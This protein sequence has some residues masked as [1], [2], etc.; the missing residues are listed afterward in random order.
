MLHNP[1][2]S[3]DRVR[4][5]TNVAMI[6]GAACYLVSCSD[7]PTS[8]LNQQVS[9]TSSA[10]STARM[11]LMSQ[12][13]YAYAIGDLF[14]PDVEVTQTIP[15]APR[16]TGLLAVGTGV[17]A[18]T[19]SMVE[20]FHRDS[21]LIAEQVVGKARREFLVPCKPAGISAA[22]A[23]C[24]DKFITTVGRRLFRRPL[25]EAEHKSMVQAAG[26]GAVRLKDFYAGLSFT[27]A[28]MI[29]SPQ[30]MLLTETTEVDPHNARRQRLT[31]YAKAQR[32]SLF[33]WDSIPDE[34]L[35]RAAE[36]GDL[37]TE[38]GV[39][40]QIDRLV[41]SPQLERGVRAFFSDMLA[42]ET[43]AD[44]AKDNVIYPAFTQAT[45]PEAKEQ[46]LRMIA[47]HLVA[48]RG[49]YRELFTSRKT[50]VTP[51]LA[52]L[53]GI[54][55]PG[56]GWSEY[57]IPQSSQR[58]GLLSQVGFTS[59]YAHPGRSSPTRR[60]KAIREL[61][62]CQ[63]VPDPPANV[64]FSGFEDPRG[65]M[66]TARDR[67]TAHATNPVCAGCHKITDP[68]GL[69]LENFDG[70]GQFRTTEG[71]AAIDPSGTLDGVAF[72][73]PE[74]LGKALHDSPALTSCLVS[75]LYSFAL[76]KAPGANE[77]DYLETLRAKFAG[78]GYRV[79]DL[80]R[81]ISNDAAFFA[82]AAAPTTVAG[83][84]P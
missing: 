21:H 83:V 51:N 82:L 42:F 53:M 68:I 50:F 12:D 57:E 35:L 64:D 4:R 66:N 52:I 78:A 72:N 7:A 1:Y 10:A 15:R 73:T 33:F 67:L 31:G 26:E 6:I 25:S 69:S 41:N 27:L 38:R 44:V 60:G 8:H 74:G 71:D 28:G 81:M 9:P 47:H 2:S 70:A 62:L 54:I 55:A 29:S 24:A 59:L 22:D 40:Q 84:T 20:R 39:A 17:A 5:L 79:P 80:M 43:F 37:H 36:R 56:P 23:A 18:V 45:V 14:G 61:V 11:R 16:V 13:E 65:K 48:E 76:A 32:L 63:K 58:V 3:V 19:P 30:F 75:R 46:A 77:K 49:D 34:Q